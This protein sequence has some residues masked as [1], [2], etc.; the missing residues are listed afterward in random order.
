MVKKSKV[1]GN[2][3][4]PTH[5]RKNWM[6]LL[7]ASIALVLVFGACKK[8]NDQSMLVRKS[9]GSGIY[10]AETFD[11]GGE[12]Y[13]ANAHPYTSKGVT[14]V[15][16]ANG[17][18]GS[19]F[20]IYT[21]NMDTKELYSS[22]CGHIGSAHFGGNHTPSVNL[23]NKTNEFIND[24]KSQR[25]YDNILK[26]FNYIYGKWGSLDQW[27]LD[28]TVTEEG[29]T[30][31]ITAMSVWVLLEDKTSAG[32]QIDEATCNWQ[33]VNNAVT[34]VVNA[35]KGGTS[36]PLTYV[37]EFVYLAHEGFPAD[38]GGNKN[39]TQCQPQIIPLY[40]ETPTTCNPVVRPIG[41]CDDF[42]AGKVYGSCDSWAYGA[43]QIGG[44]VKFCINGQL[45]N[46]PGV[47]NGVNPYFGNFAVGE[48]DANGN[49]CNAPVVFSSFCAD[50]NSGGLSC[51]S[52]VNV[53]NE[54]FAGTVGAAL[55]ANIIKMFNYVYATYGSVNRWPSKDC[56]DDREGT[57]LIAQM[58]LWRVLH[59]EMDCLE[60]L[61]PAYACYN[62]AINNVIAN[63]G[64][65]TGKGPITDIAFLGQ[66]GDYDANGHTGRI[67]GQYNGTY[68]PQIVPIV[69]EQVLGPAYGSVTATKKGNVPN[70]LGTLNPK[71]GNA[72]FPASYNAN[73]IVYNS[74]HFCFAKFTRNELLAG[75]NLDMVVG[76]KF[77]IVGKATAKIVGNNIEVV[78]ENFGKGDFGVI[79]F[80]KAMTSSFP[81][82]GNIHSQKEADLKSQLGAT[83]G[84]NH[85]NN[86]VVP[87]P[88]GNDIYLYIHC[89]TIQFF[90]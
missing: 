13:V 16:T 52:L 31:L 15:T 87:C 61:D 44:G 50:Y 18:N 79:A 24:Y 37:T 14:W 39:I 2:A 65:F 27:N 49:C 3:V 70:I 74:N 83:T 58:A 81:K 64:T 12:F 75:V 6:R 63:Y 25:V 86:L 60:I 34:E 9:V 62:I 73:G 46:I 85:N 36:I 23:F 8:D 59:A 48:K 32:V 40:K 88:T 38:L 55:K 22:F 10:D 19:F 77:D 76:N 51:A 35:V 29:A 71:N 45:L 11:K 69:C 1:N 17:T 43:D 80:N 47:S 53:A 28:G 42:L 82:N 90:Q 56:C 21:E 26:A 67:S 30:K 4:A 89:G 68:Q 78:I 41:N 72:Q 7:C 66:V 5:V 57:K 33:V 84:F 54:R 20:N